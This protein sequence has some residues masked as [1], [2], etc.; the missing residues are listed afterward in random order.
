M[1][2][3]ALTRDPQLSCLGPCTD[4]GTRGGWGFEDSVVGDFYHGL[5][6]E[7]LTLRSKRH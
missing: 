4:D 7:R 2:P 6:I 3:T 5:L 1:V